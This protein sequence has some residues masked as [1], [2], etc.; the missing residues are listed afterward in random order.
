MCRPFL[1]VRQAWPARRKELPKGAVSMPIA[2]G[3]S[4]VREIERVDPE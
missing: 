2:I 1:L 4:V 3:D